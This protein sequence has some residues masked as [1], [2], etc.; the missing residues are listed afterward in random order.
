MEDLNDIPQE[1]VERILR[2]VEP[3]YDGGPRMPGYDINS[4]EHK[5]KFAEG[6]KKVAPTF[7][8]ALSEL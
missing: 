1:D 2:G 4:E 7:M 5:R 8:R 6:V 3:P